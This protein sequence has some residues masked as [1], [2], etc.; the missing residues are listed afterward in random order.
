MKE[1]GGR[2]AECSAAATCFRARPSPADASDKI[3]GALAAGAESEGRAPPAYRRPFA[4]M[5]TFSPR[6]PETLARAERP[7]GRGR[8]RDKPKPSPAPKAESSRSAPNP[9]RPQISRG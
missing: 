9:R 4:T 8:T 3:E 6:G 2:G 7:H 1:R 5:S